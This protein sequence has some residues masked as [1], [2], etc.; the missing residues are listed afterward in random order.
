MANLDL[1]PLVFAAVVFADGFVSTFRAL[2]GEPWSEDGGGVEV[3]L[4][5]ADYLGRRNRRRLI[6]CLNYQSDAGRWGQAKD[7]GW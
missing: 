1:D 6:D 3:V 7:C 4:E 5:V 2:F